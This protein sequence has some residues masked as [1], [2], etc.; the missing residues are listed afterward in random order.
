MSN[1]RE[2]TADD[3]YEAQNDQFPGDKSGPT[4]DAGEVSNPAD[5]AYLTSGERGR[6]AGTTA[7]PQV[8]ADDQA[9]MGMLGMDGATTNSDAQLGMWPSSTHDAGKIELTHICRAR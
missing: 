6:K 1:P 4:A 5:P 9:D 3:A 2:R 7:G 8:V